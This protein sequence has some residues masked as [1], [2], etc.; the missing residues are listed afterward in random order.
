MSLKARVKMTKPTLHDSFIHGPD[1]QQLY[2]G[3]A[4]LKLIIIAYIRHQAIWSGSKGLKVLQMR[5]CM[6]IALQMHFKTRP[7]AR[8]CSL[9]PAAQAAIQYVA[10]LHGR[11]TLCRS[12]LLL[13]RDRATSRTMLP[14]TKAYGHH[15][16][17]S[18][19]ARNFSLISSPTA[20]SFCLEGAQ[21]N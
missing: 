15:L 11:E 19:R 2:H 8:A 21:C 18:S 17:S 4:S 13:V 3:A 5:D 14:L 16:Y 20:S 12:P 10:H 1:R 7:Y 6:E 9:Q